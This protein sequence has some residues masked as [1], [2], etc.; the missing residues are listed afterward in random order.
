MKVA[1]DWRTP[2]AS[3]IRSDAS[4]ELEDLLQVVSTVVMESLTP[5]RGELQYLVSA[6][7]RRY[8]AGMYENRGRREKVEKRA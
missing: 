2:R 1:T 6:R 5:E 7:C 3:R 8:Q 4:K